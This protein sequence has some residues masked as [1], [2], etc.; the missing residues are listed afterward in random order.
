ME[1][2]IQKLVGNVFLSA[3]AISYYGGFTGVYRQEL[4]KN[5]VA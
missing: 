4:I 1:Q 5:W 2:D 3:A